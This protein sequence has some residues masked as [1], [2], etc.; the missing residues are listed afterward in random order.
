MFTHGGFQMSHYYFTK[1]T[2]H[3]ESIFVQ[4]L[5]HLATSVLICSVVFATA[6]DIV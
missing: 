6:E 1:E 2:R 5:E 3:N 4:V